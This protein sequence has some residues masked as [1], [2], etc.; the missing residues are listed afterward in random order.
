M[1]T[2]STNFSK[3]NE[4]LQQDVLTQLE[5][6]QQKLDLPDDV[7]TAL[8]HHQIIAHQTA[9]AK[10]S[11]PL[12][13]QSVSLK[14]ASGIPLYQ[15]LL[16]LGTEFNHQAKLAIAG[17]ATQAK[18]LH[19][20]ISTRPPAISQR[21][22]GLVL[23]VV[24]VG[25][26]AVAIS[27]VPQRTQTP[28]K[29]EASFSTL[30]MQPLDKDT[31]SF[32]IDKI[33]RK[34]FEQMDQQY[35]RALDDGAI[36]LLRSDTRKVRP[37]TLPKDDPITQKIIQK[38]EAK[39]KSHRD[40]WNRNQKH[41]A[42]ARQ[43][44]NQGRLSA[45]IEAEKELKKIKLLGKAL[46]QGSPYWNR[47]IQPAKAAISSTRTALTTPPPS[48]PVIPAAPSSNDAAPY[49]PPPSYS[50]PS[51]SPPSYSP[52]SYSPPSYSPPR[53]DPSPPPSTP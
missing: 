34:H 49:T 19:L 31:Y 10:T 4:Q 51:Y 14:R 47:K 5:P 2:K 18:T 27:V 48:S 1:W 17:I 35:L 20:Q 43:L 24:S 40:E 38:I 37:D 44:L 52:P 26:I 50:P 36:N 6:I 22:A 28:I 32:F 15:T 46:K 13:A 39:V 3:L 45:L 25:A 33:L 9:K 23:G 21:T 53:S 29:V 7:A 42:Q 41:L 12:I 30:K 8:I 16:T 11:P